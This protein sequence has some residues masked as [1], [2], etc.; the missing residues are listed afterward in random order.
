MM[1]QEIQCVCGFTCTYMFRASRL[2]FCPICNMALVGSRF[3]YA[4]NRTTH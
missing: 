1:K 4:D 3:Q 2:C